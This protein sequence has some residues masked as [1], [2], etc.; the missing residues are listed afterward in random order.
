VF[1][2]GVC[3]YSASCLT[4]ASS[5]DYLHLFPVWSLLLITGR[6]IQS[7][8]TFLHLSR[9]CWFIVNFERRSLLTF[10]SQNSDYEIPLPLHKH[11]TAGYYFMSNSEIS[12]LCLFTETQQTQSG[13]HTIFV[14]LTLSR[15]RRIPKPILSVVICLHLQVTGPKQITSPAPT[16]LAAVDSLNETRYSDIV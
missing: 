4:L 5:C 12:P 1:H 2:P 15:A 6:V 3:H 9:F 8:R 7:V 14:P 16:N 10:G 13:I 11:I